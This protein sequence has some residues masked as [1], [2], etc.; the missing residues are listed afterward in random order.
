MSEL[1]VA[2]IGV[3]KMG[4]F[5]VDSLSRRVRGARVHNLRSV[6]V[7]VPRNALTVFTGWIASH[8]TLGQKPLEVLREE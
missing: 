6:D 8:R 2:V 3:G 4:A 7:D 5:H 1:R